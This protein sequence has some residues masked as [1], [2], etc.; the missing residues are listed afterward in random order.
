MDGLTRFTLAYLACLMIRVLGSLFAYAYSSGDLWPAD[1]IWQNLGV[2]LGLGLSCCHCLVLTWSTGTL[3]WLSTA[4]CLAFFAFWWLMDMLR[5]PHKGPFFFMLSLVAI[6]WGLT[7]YR[8]PGA[9]SRLL[10]TVCG[11]GETPET[12]KYG[13]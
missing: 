3:R 12:T 10:P 5:F 11:S 6:P 13:R 7:R 2:T 4:G 8:P 9:A 1:R